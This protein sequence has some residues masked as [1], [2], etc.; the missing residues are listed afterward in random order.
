MR[1][2]RLWAQLQKSGSTLIQNKLDKI[3]E[4][5]CSTVLQSALRLA[6]AIP[7]VRLEEGKYAIFE[8]LLHSCQPRNA[9]MN[10]F[11]AEMKDP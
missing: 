11:D 7:E 9:F 3:R 6:R 10:N 1:S 8:T 5:F 4:T 2:V